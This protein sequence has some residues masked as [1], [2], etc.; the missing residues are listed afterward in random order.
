MNPSL[1]AAWLAEIA[2][3]TYRSAANKDS[4]PNRPIKSLPLPSEYVATF[5]V[6]G[7]LSFIPAEGARAASAFGWGLVL[8]TLLNLWEP[9]GTVKKVSAAPQTIVPIAK[10]RTT[11]I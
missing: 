1:M 5:V 6:Y 10:N 9:D 7:A 11:T 2:I 8:A 4:I 3:I